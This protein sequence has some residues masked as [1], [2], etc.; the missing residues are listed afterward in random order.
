MVA[1][2][3]THIVLIDREHVSYH[4]TNFSNSAQETDRQ[5]IS[6]GVGR[7]A[8]DQVEGGVGCSPRVD[9]AVGGRYTDVQSPENV[10]FV[11]H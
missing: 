9:R 6:E 2:P 8:S 11:A 3:S 5:G 10:D 4:F 1:C 7:R